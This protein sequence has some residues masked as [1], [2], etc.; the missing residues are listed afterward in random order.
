MNSS[1][2]DI[3]SANPH[4]WSI[5]PQ[6]EYVVV[7]ALWRMNLWQLPRQDFDTNP[8]LG[9]RQWTFCNPNQPFLDRDL[10]RHEIIHSAPK[11]NC[12]TRNHISSLKSLGQGFVRFFNNHSRSGDGKRCI[13]SNNIVITSITKWIRR[14]VFHCIKWCMYTLPNCTSIHVTF[15]PVLALEDAVQDRIIVTTQLNLPQLHTKKTS[16][17]NVFVY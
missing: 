5:S 6:M 11:Q 10:G 8:K 7:G 3:I 15:G 16:A 2:L 14:S 4:R 17:I 12:S 9:I 13:Y 1:E